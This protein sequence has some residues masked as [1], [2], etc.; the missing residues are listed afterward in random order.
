MRMIIN[1]LLVLLGYYS[2]SALSACDDIDITFLI[3]VDSILNEK[4]LVTQFI[5][6][7]VSDGSS[8]YDGFDVIIYGNNIPKKQNKNLLDLGKTSKTPQRWLKKKAIAQEI[9]TAFDKIITAQTETN[10]NKLKSVSLS[11]AI[12]IAKRASKPQRGHKKR[13]KLGKGVGLHD[14]EDKYFI[15][16]YFNTITDDTMCNLLTED[17]EKYY[18]MKGQVYTPVT[19]CQGLLDNNN[20]RNIFFNFT[21]TMSIAMERIFAITCQAEIESAQYNGRLNLANH[22]QWIDPDTIIAC[23]LEHIKNERDPFELSNNSY[24]YAYD[25]I[26]DDNTFKLNDYLIADSITLSHIKQVGCTLPVYHINDIKAVRLQNQSAY[27]FLVLKIFVS[28][29]K[30]PTEY[31]LNA[32]VRGNVG[33]N[34]TNETYTYS[35]PTYNT[36]IDAGGR[37]LLFIEE[38]ISWIDEEVVELVEDGWTWVEDTSISVYE[39]AVKVAEDLIEALGDL[40]TIHE[41]HDTTLINENMKFNRGFEVEVAGDWTSGPLTVEGT[42]TL[43]LSTFIG[44]NLES[45]LS[46]DFDWDLVGGDLE[47]ALELTTEWNMKFNFTVEIIAELSVVLQALSWEQMFLFTIGPVPVVLKPFFKLDFG[48]EFIPIRIKAGI[49]C[50]Y[51]ETYV[52]SFDY[53]S[54]RDP[55]SESTASRTKDD[56]TCGYIFEIGSEEENEEDC[57]VMQLGFDITASLQIGIVFYEIITSAA[58]GILTVP[59][60]ITV[61]EFIEERGGK[62][63][64]ASCGEGESM[65]MSFIIEEITLEVNIIVFVDVSTITDALTKALQW[66]PS[67][68]EVGDIGEDTLELMKSGVSINIWTGTL[69]S[70]LFLGSIALEGDDLY[71]YLDDYYRG[72]CCTEPFFPCADQLDFNSMDDTFNVEKMSVGADGTIYGYTNT[73]YGWKLWTYTANAWQLIDSYTGTYQNSQYLYDVSVSNASSIWVV[74]V[75][76]KPM[77]LPICYII[78]HPQQTM[79]SG[80]YYSAVSSGSDGTVY[81]LDTNNTAFELVDGNWI[82]RPGQWSDIAVGSQDDIWGLDLAG[83]PYEMAGGNLISHVGAPFEN[84]EFT[85]ISVGEDGSVFAIDSDKHLFIWDGIEWVWICIGDLELDYVTVGTM[86]DNKIGVIDSDGVNWLVTN[87]GT[88][89]SFNL[90]VKNY[91]Y[92]TVDIVDVMSFTLDIT[93]HSIPSG[94]SSLFHVGNTNNKRLPG[95]WTHPTHGIYFSVNSDLAANFVYT[96][97]GDIDIEFGHTYRIQILYTQNAFVIVI[98]GIVYF[99]KY[100][101][102]AYEMHSNYSNTNIYISDPWWGAADANVKVIHMSR[103]SFDYDLVLVNKSA[104][105]GCYIHDN[106]NNAMDRYVGNGFTPSECNTKCNSEYFG[107]QQGGKCWC[108]D[109]YTNAIQYGVSNDCDGYGNG[110]IYANDLYVGTMDYDLNDSYVGPFHV[111]CY[112]DNINSVR[113]MDT[114]YQGPYTIESCNAECN[115]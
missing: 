38:I 74:M 76:Y 35:Q 15:F 19:D 43:K 49:D 37:R 31:I 18:F 4:Q 42:G 40:F 11:E 24:I 5:N 81:A 73:Q 115:T 7:V 69:S 87:T 39:G 111:G 45:T 88:L 3:D 101:H 97:N 93:I 53:V 14:D 46:F 114:R 32:N 79:Y 51:G 20:T 54:G 112:T 41:A 90:P 33:Q 89:S 12:N 22:V 65:V 98:D 30:T 107:I 105:L 68:N 47:I 59:F 1:F 70:Y 55:V 50:S 71:G 23:H 58:E 56:F 52:V 26:Y 72:R 67:D 91:I 36:T 77:D 62:S 94:F 110:G 16:D 48:L 29:P 108:G 6:Q 61:P 8:E 100:S 85:Q 60:R 57:P 103:G 10:V 84:T 27:D 21:S 13:Q 95:L 83:V 63:L 104:H 82:S 102:A 17:P 75:K 64:T 96:T 34:Y 106:T 80:Y 92:D 28:F 2:V 99:E 78:Q 44:I 86:E 25:Y 66:G 9:E 113:A 109:S